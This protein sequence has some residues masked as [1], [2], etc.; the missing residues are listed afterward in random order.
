VIFLEKATTGDG[1]IT[2]IEVAGIAVETGKPLSE[3]AAVMTKYPQIMVNVRVSRKD[4]Y[5]HSDTI[6]E[7][8]KAAA[9]ELGSS[10]RLL[11]RP[12]GTEPVVRVMGEGK[13][14]AKVDRI[15][16]SLAEIIQSELC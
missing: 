1:L 13:D 4:D 7:A 8:V 15:V 11:V 16:Q 6:A 12:S 10:G 14:E 2:A 5:Y 9:A 3:L